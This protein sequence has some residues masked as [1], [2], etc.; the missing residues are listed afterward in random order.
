ML[1][2][3][4]L[5]VFLPCFQIWIL[6]S[7]SRWDGCIFC[8]W[9]GYEESDGAIKRSP[10]H[11]CPG[12]LFWEWQ[13]PLPLAIAPLVTAC[14]SPA[15]QD[16][17]WSQPV[18]LQW[19]KKNTKKKP[20]SK[21]PWPWFKRCAMGKELEMFLVLD[22]QIKT[23][24]WQRAGLW[25]LE[26]A[27]HIQRDLWCFMCFKISWGFQRGGVSGVVRGRWGLVVL[28][29]KSTIR[30]RWLCHEDCVLFTWKKC[31]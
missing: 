18:Y 15:E 29:P 27:W 13:A 30:S 6:R 5:R 20:A 31:S 2:H 3:K 23:I 14:A 22:T 1:L 21:M 19:K 9:R 25:N 12:P 28:I 8:S 4:C 24:S 17:A 7:E 11:P 16:T 10:L 26:C